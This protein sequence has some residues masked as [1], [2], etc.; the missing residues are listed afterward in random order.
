MFTIGMFTIGVLT[1]GMFDISG[2]LWREDDRCGFYRA[3]NGEPG[4]CNPNHP[5]VTTDTFLTSPKQ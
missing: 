3:D 4:Q 2:Q 1:I 5:T